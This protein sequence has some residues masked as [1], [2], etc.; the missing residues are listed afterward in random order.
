MLFTGDNFVP[1]FVSRPV[2]P[3]TN[4]P[5]ASSTHA[6]Q[7]FASFVRSQPGGASI[8]AP[9][10]AASALEDAS[11]E[12]TQL[13][14]RAAPR[15]GCRVPPTPREASHERIIVLQDDARG[16]LHCLVRLVPRVERA[17]V[18]E[19]SKE[20]LVHLGVQPDEVAAK[21]DP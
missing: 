2:V 20:D 18:A 4:T 11:G 5:T 12:S 13:I 17:V 1:A 7:S 6:G 15:S 14:D 3:S 16:K 19:D 21:R 8:P 9:S 10:V